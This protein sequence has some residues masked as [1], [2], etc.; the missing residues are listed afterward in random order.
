VGP[1]PVARGRGIPPQASH[2]HTV[3]DVGKRAQQTNSVVQLHGSPV[4]VVIVEQVMHADADLQ[5]A[6]VQVANLAW[7]RPPQQFECLMLLEKRACIEFFDGLKQ[8]WR[9]CRSAVP[10]QVGRPESLEGAG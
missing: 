4:E 6:F 3:A 2:V 9:G 7:R 8:L 10:A 1:E 5:D